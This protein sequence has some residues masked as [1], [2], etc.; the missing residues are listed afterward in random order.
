[1]IFVDGFPTPLE[2]RELSL[3]NQTLNKIVLTASIV[4]SCGRDISGAG[5]FRMAALISRLH[6]SLA[7]RLYRCPKSVLAF[8]TNNTS[9]QQTLT[10]NKFNS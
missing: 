6:H 10:C 7:T 5:V 4:Y 9:K 2:L 3:V 8:G 1:M